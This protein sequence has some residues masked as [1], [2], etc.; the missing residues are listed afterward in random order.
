M[1]KKI[2]FMFIGICL[3]VCANLNANEKV[4][5]KENSNNDYQISF[6]KAFKDSPSFGLVEKMSKEGKE[7]K[8]ASAAKIMLYIG[9]AGVVI[10]SV[11]LILVIVGA[12]LY[13]VGYDMY[14]DWRNYGTNKWRD[15]RH[16]VWAGYA[17]M[18]VFIPF[19]SIGIIMT[20]AGFVLWAIFSKKSQSASLFMENRKGVVLSDTQYQNNP[21]MGIKF[22]F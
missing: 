6:L 2:V 9:I 4:G 18:G 15:G 14:D 10:A 8:Y 20:V 13:G 3:F 16:M 22:S 11:S 5:I 21:A 17:L 19:L 1:K 12:V 7:A